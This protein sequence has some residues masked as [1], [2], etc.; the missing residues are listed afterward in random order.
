MNLLPLKSSNAP[1]VILRWYSVLCFKSSSGS[2]LIIALDK[3]DILLSS[4]GITSWT[5]LVADSIMVKSPWDLIIGSLNVTDRDTEVWTPTALSAGVVKVI[6]GAASS[7]DI[8]SSVTG[9]LGG[10]I[11]FVGQYPPPPLT[12]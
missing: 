12:M 9:N 11:P 10:I 6:Y 8:G 3:N 4:T 1:G 7:V 5:A 2:I